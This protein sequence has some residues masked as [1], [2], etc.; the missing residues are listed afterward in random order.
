[1]FAGNLNVRDSFGD[2]KGKVLN[3][4]KGL[5]CDI[6]NRICSWLRIS[7]SDGIF[8]NGIKFLGERSV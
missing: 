6:W 7:S 3:H 5:G 8:L 2:T 4:I 1:M